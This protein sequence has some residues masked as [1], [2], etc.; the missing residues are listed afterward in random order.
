MGLPVVNP[1]LH[2]KSRFEHLLVAKAGPGLLKWGWSEAQ[3]I[4][5]NAKD[6]IALSNLLISIYGV[7][8]VVKVGLVLD[9]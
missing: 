7:G 6:V 9:I 1:K 5:N 4:N 8:V 3:G 2:Q